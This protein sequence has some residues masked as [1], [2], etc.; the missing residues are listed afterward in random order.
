MSFE[1][2]AEVAPMSGIDEY[3]VHNYPQ[4]VRVMSTSDPRAF[5]RNWFTCQ[6]RTG[7]LYVITGT[8]FYPNQD[9]ADSYALVNL[10]GRQTHVR[11]HRRL[12]LNRM[13]LT[14]GPLK[15]EVIEPF[16][17]WRLTLGDNPYGI[18]YELYWHD[19][20]RPIFTSGSQR[21]PTG[22]TSPDHAGYETFGAIEGW[23]EV[24]GERFTVST[25]RF[26]GSR[27]HHWGARNGV[28][29]FEGNPWT[30]HPGA[31]FIEFKDWSVWAGKNLY[32]NGDAR[33]AGGTWAIADRRFR[34]DPETKQFVEGV[35]TNVSE[36]GEKRDLHMRRL[37]YQ[38]GH[39][40]VGGYGPPA[41]DGGPTHGVYPGEDRLYG[42]SYDL[43]KPDVRLSL[44]GIT[45][46]HVEATSNGETA[47]GIWECVD[48]I[49]YEKCRDGAPGHGFLE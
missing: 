2:G 3:L 18:R 38:C 47:Y 20:K 19:T 13:D 24:E 32:P 48:P 1:A 35:I 22:V 49:L 7:D 30:H 23:V 29:P 46:H 21:L 28:G 26:N 4:P 42:G 25:D 36:T 31:Q 15:Q 44:I 27:D 5:E 14:M 16:K 43:A 41:P 9:A 12:G 11:Y 17:T 33:P 10:R 8:G 39:L 45:D 34:F 40:R 6:D 37:G